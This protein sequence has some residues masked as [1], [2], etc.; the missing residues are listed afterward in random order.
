M[1]NSFLIINIALL[2]FIAFLGVEIVYSRLEL[3]LTDNSFYFK[4]KL[5][6]GHNNKRLDMLKHRNYSKIV[7]ANIFNVQ[8]ERKEKV[9]KKKPAYKDIAKLKKTLLKLKLLGTIAGDNAEDSYAVIQDQKSG[10]QSL[11]QTGQIVQG[12]EVIKILRQKAIIKYNGENQVL[13][14]DG[15]PDSPDLPEID[16]L[17]GSK[18]L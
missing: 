6:T 10:M 3:F 9:F 18:A 1:K 12:A 15:L 13:E 4:K 7:S 14:M 17:P 11:Y 2:T 16:I 5:P 8:T